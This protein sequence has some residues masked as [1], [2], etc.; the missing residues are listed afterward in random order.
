MPGYDRTGPVGA[1]P[2]MGRSLGRCGRPDGRT[3][4]IEDTYLDSRVGWF[5][6]PW[7]GGR[8]R[9]F[10]RRG[11]GRGRGSGM[12]WRDVDDPV[13]D[14]LPPRQRQAFLRRRIQDLTAQLDRLKRLHSDDSAE[15][16][17]AP[18]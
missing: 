10:G 14:D 6:R 5:T 7:G 2:R 13:A 12:G 15:D 16:D 18:E 3:T 8:G 4:G 11:R 17:Q 1:G 9:G